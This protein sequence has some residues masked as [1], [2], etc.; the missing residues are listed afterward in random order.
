MIVKVPEQRKFVSNGSNP[1]GDLISYIEGEKEQSQGRELSLTKKIENMRFDDLLNYA[2][3]QI[4]K[5]TKEEKCIAICTNGI[6]DITTASLE[7]NA[8]AARNT[9]CKD[10][11]YHFILSWPEHEKPEPE[12]IFDAA[13][14]AIKALGLSEHQYVIAIHGNTDN[15]HCHISVNRVHPITFKSRNLTWPLKNLHQAAR[16][17]EIKHNWTHDNGIWIVEIDGHGKKHVV[18]NKE[19]AKAFANDAPH[20]HHDI[21]KK[22][23]LPA[24][25]D[26]ESLDSW[27][28]TDVTK[29]LKRDLKNLESW[30]A[31]HSWL[32]QYDITLSDSGGGGMRLHAIS[33]ATGEILDLAAS[34]G[35]RLLKRPELEKR[36]GPFANSIDIACKVPDLTHLTP[37]QKAKGIEHVITNTLDHRDN[38]DNR[39]V[40]ANAR[41]P[42]H[43][44]RHQQLATRDET[45]GS[46]GLHELPAGG[47]DVREQNPAMPLPHPLQNRLG[48][49]QTRQ[50][51][52]VRRPGTDEIRGR[53]ERSQRSLTRDD[54]KR[55]ERKEQRATARADLRY[56]YSQY[57]GFVR[58]GDTEHYLRT[59]EIR[60]QHSYALKQIKE[61]SKAAKA[62]IPKALSIETRLVA[63]IEI[64][65]ES[66][67]RKLVQEASHQNQTRALNATRTPPLSWRTWLYEQ[68]NLGD[69]AALS[70]LRG[71]VYQAQRDAKKDDKEAQAQTDAA[72]ADYREQQYKKVMARLL[73]EEKREAAIRSANSNNMRPYEADALLAQY[74]GI[75]WRVTGNGNVEY[76]SQGGSHLFTDRGSRVT[77]DRVYVTD[78]EIRLA[79]V[80]AQQKFGKEITLTGEDIEFTKRM[81]RL[82]DDMGIAIL[83]PEMQIEIENHRKAR[84]LEITE[85][86]TITPESITEPTNEQT[87][88]EDQ[89]QAT[90]SHK[91]NQ[92]READAPAPKTPQQHQ[93]QTENENEN[94]NE[95][96]ETAPTHPT[97]KTPQEQ[98]R[99]LVLAID[100]TATFVEPDPTANART[101]SGKVAATLK[102]PQTGFAQRIGGG[103]YALHE[104]DAPAHADNNVLNVRYNADK[105]T[106]TVEKAKGQGE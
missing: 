54:S 93:P 69:K 37:V 101:Y 13:Q 7:M 76:S 52:N 24:W 27:L 18:Q 45:Q 57:K 58:D 78:D 65:A 66:L 1:F 20:A 3:N 77:F 16:E 82:A 41:P 61:K 44:I 104:I 103:K 106:V 8:V 50:D 83:N 75:Q 29:A 80:H 30:P 42:E 88:E 34:K 81:A 28:K 89:T 97:E 36:W 74:I 2:T 4:D 17:S 105:I 99:A 11:A 48:D 51:Q 43:V 32:S 38:P 56:R 100:P 21:D 68:S 53:G 98:L 5:E 84:E 90:P 39:G 96:A 35:L 33:S 40:G 10:P 26:P 79:L 92:T 49:P 12:K 95:N 47:L 102:T 64:D 70:A 71:I 85:A 22:K 46:G 62:A 25:H 86:I 63:L 9:R 59:K 91:S 6:L 73:E 23:I 72:D 31:L 94:G 87:I 55:A 15:M 14:H 60:L 67:R 19:H